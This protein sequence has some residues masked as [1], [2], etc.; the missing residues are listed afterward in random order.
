MERMTP[1][2]TLERIHVHLQTSKEFCFLS[3]IMMMGRTILCDKTATAKT[4]GRNTWYG[5][6]WFMEELEN[7][8][9]RAFVVVHENYH[10][11]F[12]HTV[13]WKHLYKKNARLANSAADAVINASIKRSDP[14]CLI[15]EP[16]K[17]GV[18]LDWVTP[19]MDTFDVFTKLE[20]MMQQGGGKGKGKNGAGDAENDG[21]GEGDENF[22]EHDWDSI[23]Q[24][25]EEEK[26]AVEA[27]VDAALRQGM[28]LAGKMQGNVDRAITELT[29]PEIPW[30]QV[31]RDFVKASCKGKDDSTWRRPNRRFLDQN[32]YLP[33]TISTSVGKVVVGVD[34]SGSIY[35]DILNKFLGEVASI[36]LEVQPEELVLMYWGTRVAQVEKYRPGMY[37][38][39]VGSTKPKGGGGTSPS[40]VPTYIK[41]NKIDNVDCII[42]LTDGYVGNDWG[43]QV[44]WPAPVLW[45]I[46]GDKDATPAVGVKVFAR[47]WR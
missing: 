31:L 5:T 12:R 30:K 32:I 26:K 3:G 43:Q 21:S 38:M 13:I 46:V 18:Y 1:E 15:V 44:G 27:E 24:L 45:V 36:G 25:S 4:D 23:D 16:P 11:A 19:E 35:G 9:Q 29:Q 34:T 17:H 39:L 42:M 10:K 14:Q 37:E 6:K 28:M 40:C 33:S 7:N 8:K 41:E 47:D 2:Q 20:Q 22:D